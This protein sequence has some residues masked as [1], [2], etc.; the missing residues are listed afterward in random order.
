MA[1]SIRSPQLLQHLCLTAT[2]LL[3]GSCSLLAEVPPTYSLYL[4]QSHPDWI[5]FGAIASDPRLLSDVTAEHLTDR[6]EFLRQERR[7]DDDGCFVA[8]YEPHPS[9]PAAHQAFTAFRTSPSEARAHASLVLEG[10]VTDTAPGLFYGTQIGSL[11]EIAVSST[12]FCSP[13][14]ADFLRTSFGADPLR[15]IY[16]FLPIARF[17]WNGASL[18]VRDDRM[19]SLPGKGD[20]VALLLYRGFLGTEQ[21]E[22]LLNS[23]HV[24]SPPNTQSVVFLE[25]DTTALFVLGDP[26]VSLQRWSERDPALDS[27]A[28]L[29]AL[30]GSER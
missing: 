13:A 30:L 19:T 20:L 3:A 8:G 9:S 2:L 6:I 4:D 21:R 22:R 12:S 16:V 1:S 18:C 26:P 25:P 15:E 5:A 17:T 10:V 11:V 14:L 28:K 23:G 27:R 7:V 24:E 29:Q